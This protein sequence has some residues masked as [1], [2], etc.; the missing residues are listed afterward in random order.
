MTTRSARPFP[1]GPHR[2]RSEHSI[3]ALR[4]WVEGGAPDVQTACERRLAARAIVLDARRVALRAFTLAMRRREPPSEPPAP[5]W[6]DLAIDQLVG[7]DLREERAGLAPRAPRDERYA[8]LADA[9][10]VAPATVR[11]MCVRINSLD[12]DVRHAFYHLVALGKGLRRYVAEGNGPPD[13]VRELLR[14]VRWG[15]GREDARP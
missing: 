13:R 6:I 15:L 11:R 3:P 4:H 2:R 10:G 12:S 1:G 7:E 5:R 9:V 8:A 14:R